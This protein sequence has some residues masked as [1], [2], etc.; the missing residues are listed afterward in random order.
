MEARSFRAGRQQT[1]R[2]QHTAYQNS[3]AKQARY[4]LFKSRNGRRSAHYTRSGFRMRAGTLTP[5]KHTAPLEFVWSWDADLL[6]T[7]NPTTVI[8][9]REPDER[10]YVT[11][12]VDTDDPEPAEPTGNA[13]GIDLGMKD[14][15]VLSTGEKITNPRQNI[16]AAGRA[17]AGN[18]PGGACGAGA[19][20]QG[21]AL[22]QSATKQEP[23]GASRMGLPRL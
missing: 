3:F 10:W 19:S 11:F 16:L 12:A 2:H 22:P 18:N 4:P 5:A 7:L 20:R 9:S 14:F 15:A 21:S 8:V 13:V 17:V 6:E 1:L 23:S